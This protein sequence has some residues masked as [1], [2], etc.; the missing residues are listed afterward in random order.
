MD[1]SLTD[2]RRMVADTLSRFLRDAYGPELRAKV[3]HEAPGYSPEIWAKM[4]ELGIIG[5]LLPE[6]AGGFGGQG[7]DIAV[8][9]EEVGRALSTEPF[10]ATGVLGARLLAATGGPAELIEQAIAGEA[11]LA[12]AHSEPASRYDLERVETTAREEGGKWRLDGVKSVAYGAATAGRVIVSAR[13]SGGIEDADGITLFLID[14][15]GPG[16]R[17]RAYPVI[18]GG[19][20]ADLWL[21]AVEPEAVLGAVGGGFA[22][23]EAAVAAGCLALSAEALGAMEAA[24]DMTVGYLRERKQF[25]RPIGSFQAL[26]HRAVEMVIEIEQMRSAVIRAAALLEGERVERERAVSAAK[27]LAGRVGRHV[28]EE[29][30]QLHGGIAMTWEYPLGHY[31]KRLVMIDHQLGDADHHLERFGALGR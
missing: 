17:R 30:I 20:A 1:F 29:A 26:Q 7:G 3:A 14:P 9:F 24:K 23:L 27:N 18:D 25:G 22:P 13:T 2:D 11:Q 4:A 10:L 31:A 19:A 15:E 28:A 5:A 6:E 12:L 16:V 8:V 21:D